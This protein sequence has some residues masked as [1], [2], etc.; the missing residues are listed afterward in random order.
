MKIATIIIILIVLYIMISY[1]AFL[2]I[3]RKFNNYPLKGVAINIEEALKPYKELREKGLRWVNKKK[4]ED[5]F[6][7]SFDNLKLH[8]LLIKKNKPKGIFIEIHGYRS[9]TAHDIYP[10]C[11]HYYNMG[12]SLLLI[13]QRT[14]GKSEGKYL[15]FGINESKDLISWIKY[16]NKEFPNL[17]IV[18]AGVSMGASTLMLSASMLKES[19]NVK[20][21]LADSG[22]ISPIEEISYCLKY[23]LHIPP[24]LLIDMINVWSILI[25]KADLKSNNT[26]DSLNKVNIPLLLV[27]GEEDDFVPLAN[28]K[29]NYELYKGD[30]K[31][32]VTFP[33]AYHGMGYLVDP[34][35][36]I[37]TIKRF[38]NE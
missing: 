34:K 19:M 32:L 3:C 20:C 18:L 15:T 9:E 8:G 10:S 37:E 14:S 28:S 16:V 13:D 31:E 33:N 2:L 4:K 35:R 17:P 26:V 12:Y 30:E 23:Y 6:I 11:Y 24:L 27:H 7:K 36:Y 25:A 22:Y 5:I 38:L 1:I 29:K 21:L